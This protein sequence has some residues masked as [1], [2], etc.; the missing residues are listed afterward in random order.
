M[1][2]KHSKFGGFVEFGGRQIPVT[3]RTFQKIAEFEN[4]WFSLCLLPIESLGHL[5]SLC[6][7]LATKSFIAGWQETFRRHFYAHAH[8]LK[9][10]LARNSILGLRFEIWQCCRD[11]FSLDQIDELLDAMT[12]SE[13]RRFA[14][15]LD[16]K[17]DIASGTSE[18]FRIAELLRVSAK[19]EA[20]A[21][22]TQES[23]L[24]NLLKH[25]LVGSP[26]DIMETT[27]VQLSGLLGDPDRL[28]D[29][30]VFE[31]MKP[32]GSLEARDDQ[33]LYYEAADEL[34]KRLGISPDGPG[35]T[36]GGTGGS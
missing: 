35:A 3:G 9:A 17:L 20:N 32:S 26:N 5:L 10:R 28:C 11:T 7:H 18:H 6:P 16:R 31:S 14:A 34:L 15:D 8:V 24:A 12:R 27:P 4:Y 23:M 29:D 22:H 13:L 21:D 2:G 19:S 30:L 1:F 33:R 25:K 36:D